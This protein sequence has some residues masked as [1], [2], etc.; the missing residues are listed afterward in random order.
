M[1]APHA[2]IVIRNEAWGTDLESEIAVITDDV[3]MG[4]SPAVAGQHSRLLMLINDI[5]LRNLILGELAKGFGFYQS[6]PASA[7]SPVAVTPDELGDVRPRR[8]KH[9]RCHRAGGGVRGA[10]RKPSLASEAV[11]K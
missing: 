6:K 1:L 7:C 9:L 4:S 11:A 5:P 2:P 8:P 10:R 3:P